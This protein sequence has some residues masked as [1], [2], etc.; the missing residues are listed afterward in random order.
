MK[1]SLFLSIVVICMLCQNTICLDNSCI[2]SVWLVYDNFPPTT[3][4]LRFWYE[5][6]TLPMWQHWL[7]YRELTWILLY[8]LLRDLILSDTKT[9][10][11]HFASISSYFF[12]KWPCFENRWS[13][14][15][16]QLSVVNIAG[17]F[18]WF[19]PSIEVFMG[20]WIKEMFQVNSWIVNTVRFLL[21][22]TQWTWWNLLFCS[23]VKLWATMCF[24]TVLFTHRVVLWKRWRLTTAFS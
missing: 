11:L 21:C 15:S 7:N 8:V 9:A 24:S 3:I 20:L 22:F 17:T 16:L 18:G 14:F 5:T 12:V 10:V 2:L 19:L 4:I 6:L 23:S 13:T 1:V